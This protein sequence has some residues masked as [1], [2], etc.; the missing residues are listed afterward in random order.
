MTAVNLTLDEWR[1]SEKL[2]HKQLGELIGCKGHM[3]YVYCCDPA[4]PAFRM[5]RP[6]RM[7]RIYVV[8][9]G[10]VG[11]ASFYRLPELRQRFDRHAP[12]LVPREEAA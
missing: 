11:P 7:R 2:S 9:N 5:P 8:T 3:A 1:L 4:D 12:S 10:A 6:D